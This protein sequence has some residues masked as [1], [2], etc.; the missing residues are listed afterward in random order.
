MASPSSVTINH[1]KLTQN[2]LT[3]CCENITSKIQTNVK[4]IATTFDQMPTQI[5]IKQLFKQ[6]GFRGG[7]VNK[8][9]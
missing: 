7:R 9:P 8:K 3:T 6:I 4:D 1:L 2:W 5:I